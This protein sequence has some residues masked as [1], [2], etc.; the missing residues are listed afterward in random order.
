MN[1]KE[2]T[3]TPL[4]FSNCRTAKD[5]KVPASTCKSDVRSRGCDLI[6]LFWL[7]MED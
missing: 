1:N 6:P 5:R 3:L 7:R 2:K 4:R